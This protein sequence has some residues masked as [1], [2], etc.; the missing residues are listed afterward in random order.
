[1]GSDCV[2]NARAGWSVSSAFLLRFREKKSALCRND[3]FLYPGS[4][5]EDLTGSKQAEGDRPVSTKEVG[6]KS[7]ASSAKQSHARK[8]EV[9]VFSLMQCLPTFLGPHP[10]LTHQISR[11]PSFHTLL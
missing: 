11:D 3:N 7:A 10:I 9:S 4:D 6:W 5:G 8:P 1:M 2:L